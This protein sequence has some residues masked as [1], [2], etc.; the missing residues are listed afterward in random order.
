GLTK[1]EVRNAIANL[2]K[3]GEIMHEKF[4]N[5]SLVTVVNYEMYQEEADLNDEIKGTQRAHE[6]H[7]KGT[8]RAPNEEYKK[9]IYNAQTTSFD[10]KMMFKEFWDLYPRKVSKKKSEETFLKKIKDEETYERLMNGLKAAVNEWKTEKTQQKFIPHA[11]TWL[12]HERWKDEALNASE[13]SVQTHEEGYVI[14]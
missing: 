6:G 14:L 2:K 13:E 8:R 12:N 7:T 10:A 11:S 9:N 5:A 4:L 1:K 3:T